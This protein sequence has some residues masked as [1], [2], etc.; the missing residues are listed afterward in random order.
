MRVA[1][2]AYGNIAT[3]IGSEA[4]WL[5]NL[6]PFDV[7]IQA[8]HN[9]LGYG[10]DVP[11]DGRLIA[12]GADWKK[13]LEGVDV[14]VCIERCF[15]SQLCEYARSQG[16]RTVLLCN[17]EWSPPDAWWLPH[18]DLCVA[19]TD[20]AH[21]HLCN[22]GFGNV[23]RL[24][25]PI[26]LRE[27]PYSAPK[28]V[29]RVGF[30]N[31]WGGVA[32]RKG[33]QEVAKMNGLGAGIVVHSQRKIGGFYYEE[34]AQASSIYQAND[35][36]VCPSRFEGVGLTLLEAMASGCLVAA[37]DAE[38]MSEFVHAAY[39]YDAVTFLLPVKETRMVRVWSH[40]WP[41]HIVDPEAAVSKIE[42]LR[43]F[44]A[45][46]VQ[47]FSAMGR[48]YIEREHGQAAATNLWETVT[49]V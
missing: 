49:G 5:W 22:I 9:T 4:R 43:R 23:E 41:A 28:E 12:R 29:S 32:G 31:G 33:L 39:G 11:D 13:A 7:W 21:E 30:V 24:Q 16:I 35:L 6:L 14:V 1:L 26:D 19:R 27:F 37:T 3:G 20:T 2:N 38:P 36:M 25:V 45:G 18:T 17:P 46:G 42:H 34:T 8:E 15:P 44:G 40:D 47:K 10:K 48:A